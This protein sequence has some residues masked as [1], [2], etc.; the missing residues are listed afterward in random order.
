MT[1][2]NIGSWTHEAHSSIAMQNSLR[3]MNHRFLD[4]VSIAENGWSSSPLRMVGAVSAQVSP[5]ST[6]QR[7]AA[8]DCPYALFDLRFCDAGHWQ[9]RLCGGQRACAVAEELPIGHDI[10]EFVRLA[11]FFAWH[12]AS[13]SSRAAPLLLGMPERTAVAFRA[14]TIDCLPRLAIAESQ[15]LTERWND[16]PRYWT[17]LTTAA[18]RRDTTG[19]RRIQLYGLQLAAAHLA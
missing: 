12:V 13:T 19:L 11:L 7:A 8:S 9:E 4:L 18:A 10:T 14:V 17:A 3:Q 2:A 1:D 5:L 15:H 16:C 6:A